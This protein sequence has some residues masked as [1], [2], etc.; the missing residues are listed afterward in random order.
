MKI[1]EWDSLQIGM[2]A[3]VPV[4]EQIVSHTRSLKLRKGRQVVDI[5][6]QSLSDTWQMKD[7]CIYRKDVLIVCVGYKVSQ[8]S[9]IF[10]CLVIIEYSLNHNDVSNHGDGRDKMILHQ[11]KFEI[12]LLLAQVF[13]ILPSTLAL[14]TWTDHWANHLESYNI[15]NI[16]PLAG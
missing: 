5:Y 9:H 16:N 10:F 3:S 8:S 11:Y 4:S 1:L 7:F 15:I 12:C 6:S 2:E 14:F 13:H